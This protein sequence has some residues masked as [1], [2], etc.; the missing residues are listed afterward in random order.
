M[1]TH[2]NNQGSRYFQSAISAWYPAKPHELSDDI[3]AFIHILHHTLLKSFPDPL[4]E[5]EW[6]IRRQLLYGSDDERRH[7]KEL[8]GDSTFLGWLLKG[9][10]L[11]LCLSPP[12]RLSDHVSLDRVLVDIAQLWSTHYAAIS[13]GELDDSYATPFQRSVL[14]A[15]PKPTGPR[16]AQP[17]GAGCKPFKPAVAGQQHSAAYHLQSG[18]HVRGDVRGGSDATMY[19]GYMI[20]EPAM[21]LSSSKAKGALELNEHMHLAMVLHRYITDSVEEA[22]RQGPVQQQQLEVT[23]MRQQVLQ[24]QNAVQRMTQ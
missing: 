4:N 23:T 11:Q 17:I 21:G 8:T 13:Y 7:S 3:E 20:V 16:S 5:V 22:R 1:R 9:Y 14:Q 10:A 15:M 6:Q 18:V 12:Y 24:Q 2:T 19:Q